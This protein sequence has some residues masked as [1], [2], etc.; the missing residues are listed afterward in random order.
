ME[1][2]CCWTVPILIG[3]ATQATYIFQV[4][5]CWIAESKGSI[6]FAGQSWQRKWPGDK[7]AGTLRV[8]SV[9]RTAVEFLLVVVG[10]ARV[11]VSARNSGE[12]H[13]GK[14]ISAA[15]LSKKYALSRLSPTTQL[16]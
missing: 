9:R 4:V 7:V 8:P 1:V 14:S 13:Y 11:T 6:D 15:G 3:K 5:Y 10:L 12:S 16:S 2:F